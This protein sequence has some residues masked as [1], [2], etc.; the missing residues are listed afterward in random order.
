[1]LIYNYQKEFL[2]IDEKDL[3]ALGFN[4]FEDLRA[5]VTDFADLFVK[6]PGYVHNF[7]HVHWID[8]VNYADPAEEL[9]VLISV[10]AKTFKAKLSI[11]SLFL[12]DNP[13]SPAYMVHLNGLHPLSKSENE[14]LSS[15]VFERELPK[16]EPQEPKTFTT[17]KSEPQEPKA[18]TTP[19]SEPQE[20]KVEKKPEIQIPPQVE[21]PS[22][23][24]T[25]HEDDLVLDVFEEQEPISTSIKA[26]QT[27]PEENIKEEEEKTTAKKETKQVTE[28]WD[29][30]YRYDPNVA[31]KELGLPLD[32]IEEFIQD[33]IAQAKEF[34]PEIY[35]SIEDGDVDNV[36][37]LSHK[38][39]GVAANLRIEDAH[40]VLTAVSATSDMDTIHENLDIFYKII[41]KLSGETPTETTFQE[42]TV[43]DIKEEDTTQEEDFTLD[44]KDDDTLSLDF[45]DDIDDFTDIK[46]E[47]VPDKIKIPE[48]ADDDFLT[49]KDDATTVVSDNNTPIE[50][51]NKAFSK[52]TAAKEIGIDQ[53]SFNELFNDFID[54]GKSIVHKME[55]AVANDDLQICRNEAIK[56]KGMSDNMRFK[57]IG[58]TL[59]TII[60]TQDKDLITQSLQKINTSLNTISNNTGA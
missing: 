35:S 8:F 55:T 28:A 18:F 38:L 40:E 9:K 57:E 7:K 10:N 13:S 5:E 27:T 31:S 45:K 44:F 43:T 41:A 37:I 20:P 22:T 4:S 49:F 46:D 53:E 30:G 6:T 12:I 16:V 25:L 52:E 39:K 11:S 17:P 26:T 24:P 51:E 33:F 42:T 1:M 21:G 19:K 48:L 56:L 23:T 59:E 50:K 15:E 3:H 60:H 2:G 34:Q 29:N 32:L 58:D 36:K 54:E 47:D 14:N